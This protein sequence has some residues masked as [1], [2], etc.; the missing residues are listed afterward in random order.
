MR[1]LLNILWVI[2]GGFLS[3][4][5]W[6][7]AGCLWCV[8]IIGIPVGLQ[9]FKLASISLDPFGKEIRYEGGAVSF[10]LNIVWLLISGFELALGNFLIGLVLCITII[11]IPFG[12]QFFKIAALALCPFGA[13]VERVHIL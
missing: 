12:K 6:V 11:G 1:I 13:V 3:W 9:C 5:G 8:T 2:F 10:L 4:L 7:L